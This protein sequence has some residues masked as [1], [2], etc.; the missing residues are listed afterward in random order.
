MVCGFHCH[1]DP[2]YGWHEGVDFEIGVAGAGGERVAAGATGTA[3]QCP[4]STTAGYYI[5]L[6]HGNGH[7]TRYL[8]LNSPSLPVDGASVGRGAVIG[9]EGSTGYTVP[10]GFN[11]LHFETRHDAT[12]FTCGLDGTPV[13]PYA[14]STYMWIT[15]PPSYPSSQPPYGKA[16]V[17]NYVPGNGQFWVSRSTGSGLQQATLWSEEVG[18]Q[19]EVRFIADYTGDGRAD[20]G[21]YVPGNGQFWVSVSTG[22]GLQQAALWSEEVGSQ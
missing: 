7:V 9:Y 13:D 15:N 2:V 5:P 10:A 3:K 6:D 16:D 12:T 1:N 22:S 18:S 4:K 20:V 14:A 17:G 19:Y 11:H 8:R 21:N